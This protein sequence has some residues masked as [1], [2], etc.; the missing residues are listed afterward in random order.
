MSTLSVSASISDS[1]NGVST[2]ATK[3]VTTTGSALDVRILEIG[4]S[5]EEVTIATEIG[6]CGI[7]FIQN[8]DSTNYVEVGFLT[9]ETQ[10]KIPAGQF[11]LIP[12]APATASLFMKANTDACDVKVYFH[13]A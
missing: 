5:E 4:T 8:L 10:I 7:A 2:S 6:D 1:T 9:T 12:L 11:A 3:S 13:E